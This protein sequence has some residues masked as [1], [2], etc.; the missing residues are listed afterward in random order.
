[1]WLIVRHSPIKAGWWDASLLLWDLAKAIPI[2]SGNRLPLLTENNFQTSP[3]LFERLCL[4]IFRLSVGPP[5]LLRPSR[6]PAPL[7]FG[8]GEQ[9]L[10]NH[11]TSW[12]M[13]KR[14]I[15]KFHM[16][17]HFL[18]IYE[19]PSRK[20]FINLSYPK[21]LKMINW[22]KKCNNFYFHTSLRYL[23]RFH[24][25]GERSARIKIYVMIVHSASELRS[26]GLE[27]AC[28]W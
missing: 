4:L 17:Y 14:Y 1:M 5:L 15:C 18:D 13:S 12:I 21:H 2:I 26:L 6:P 25:W 9:A 16:C 22:N 11:N 10:F 3:H 8:T 28:V 20:N 24:F 19:N 7:L 23:K 27:G